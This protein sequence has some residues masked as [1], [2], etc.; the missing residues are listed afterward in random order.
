MHGGILARKRLAL[1]ETAE[2]EGDVDARRLALKEGGQVNGTIRMGDRADVES[3]GKEAE[4]LKDQVKAE[5][6][7]SASA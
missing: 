7:L 2:V 6:K 3:S 1:E 5:D 4:P